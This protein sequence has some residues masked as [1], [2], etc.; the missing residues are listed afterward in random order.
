M[1]RKKY[2]ELGWLGQLRQYKNLF[3]HHD[4]PNEPAKEGRLTESPFTPVSTVRREQSSF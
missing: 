4:K 2:F 1:V 3:Y